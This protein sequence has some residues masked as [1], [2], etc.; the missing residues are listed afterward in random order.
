MHPEQKTF[1][2]RN[3]GFAL[4]IALSMMAFVLLLL[5]STTLLTQVE[6]VNASRA[7]DQLRARENARLGLM[8]GLGNLQKFAG[9]DLVITATADAL[10][11]PGV[12]YNLNAKYWTGVWTS[13]ENGGVLA[14]PLWLVSGEMPNPLQDWLLVR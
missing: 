1:A 9:T 10:G 6:T 3:S 13:D 14:N 4:I 2:K 7:L 8:L 5:I 12:D 11:E